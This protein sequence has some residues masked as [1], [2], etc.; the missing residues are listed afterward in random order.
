MTRATVVALVRKDLYAVVR[1]RG[2][3]WPLL[4]TPILVLG[5]LPLSL[6]LLGQLVAETA[7]QAL[8]DV[9][10]SPLGAVADAGARGQASRGLPAEASW[11]IFV[12]E[13]FLSPLY[14]LVPLIVATVIAADSFAGERERGTLEALLHTP[15]SDRELVLAKFLSAWLPAVAVAWLG[16]LGYAVLANWLL[17]PVIGAVWF[18]TSGWILLALWVSPGLSALGMALMVITSARVRTLQA[19]HQLGSLVVLPIVVLLVLQ[20]SGTY[21]LSVPRIVW[22]GAGVWLV[23]VTTLTLGA[24]MLRRE[25]L[26]TRL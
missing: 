26:S 14:L 22:M 7:P 9:A 24:R 11:G 6:V 10:G 1:N 5:V 3:R 18:P 12:L 23:A 4:L 13:L 25:R 19:A 2:V 16:F 15:V 21:V 8:A 17:W 20:V